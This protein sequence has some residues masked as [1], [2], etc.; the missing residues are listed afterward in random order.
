MAIGTLLLL[1]D[2]LPDYLIMDLPLSMVVFIEQK[3]PT[4]L[5][6]TWQ[7]HDS[8]HTLNFGDNQAMDFVLA[9]NN[10]AFTVTKP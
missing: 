7:S 10:F 5:G 1:T 9:L 8:G 3:S 6:F 4:Q 2:Q